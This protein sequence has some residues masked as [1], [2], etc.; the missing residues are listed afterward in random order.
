MTMKLMVI[1]ILLFPLTFASLYSRFRHFE[2]IKPFN[3]NIRHKRDTRNPLASVK[4]IHFLALGKTFNLKLFPDNSILSDDFEVQ[5]IDG[6]G[7]ATKTATKTE[8]FYSGHEKNFPR[9]KV[10]AAY[11][12]LQR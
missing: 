5:L 7:Q 2:E 8:G 12:D 10:N 9:N 4:L 1:L 6:D 3:I 11:N